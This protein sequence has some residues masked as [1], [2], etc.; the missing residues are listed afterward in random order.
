MRI[1]LTTT[2]GI[3]Y[4]I[5]SYS[6]CILLFTIIYL[7]LSYLYIAKV[8]SSWQI[9]IF[10][11][12]FCVWACEFMYMHMPVWGS[13]RL[14]STIFLTSSPSFWSKGLPLKW[15]PTDSAKLI[16]GS[17]SPGFLHRKCGLN[18]GLY[19]CTINMLVSEHFPVFHTDKLPVM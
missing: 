10:M 17:F 3:F 13:K 9:Y 11:H 6:T 14:T 2:G 15:K 12:L 19:S 4:S 5:I 8:L 7:I 16:P 18:S 1:T